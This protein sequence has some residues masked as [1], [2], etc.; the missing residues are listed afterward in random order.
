MLYCTFL[1]SS[2]QFRRSSTRWRFPPFLRKLEHEV[3]WTSNLDR[4][5]ETAPD[6]TYLC[7]FI[8]ISPVGCQKRS[9]QCDCISTVLV[10]FTVIEKIQDY[11]VNFSFVQAR[12][13]VT[14]PD[15]STLVSAFQCH[16]L[17]KSGRYCLIWLLLDFSQGW[18][19]LYDSFFLSFAFWCEVSWRNELPCCASIWHSTLFNVDS[20]GR[21]SVERTFCA[22]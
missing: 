21:T 16:R 19:I 1:P 13:E 12:E 15:F 2:P 3:Y 5:H 20:A 22:Y 9:L 18:F 17:R 11:N 4:D 6:L 7:L 8:A 14:A 10:R